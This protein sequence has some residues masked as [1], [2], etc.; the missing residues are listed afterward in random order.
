MWSSHPQIISM[1]KQTQSLDPVLGSGGAWA[2]VI[3]SVL[4]VA[5]RGVA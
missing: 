4:E 5:Q 3:L 2:P 1:R